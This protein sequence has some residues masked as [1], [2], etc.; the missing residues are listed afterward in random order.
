VITQK[1]LKSKL[2]YSPIVG[3]FEWRTAG[4]RI[5]QGGLAGGVCRDSGYVV[6]GVMGKNYL[7]HH[8]AW[9]YMTGDWPEMDIDHKDGDR[10]NNAFSNLRLATKRQNQ[11]NKAISPLNSSGEK[12]VSFDKSTQKWRGQVGLG[13]KRV[14]VGLFKTKE[15]ATAAVRERRQELHGEFA[16]HGQ[17]KYVIEEMQNELL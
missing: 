14:H 10:S 11:W 8:L 6:I 13:D 4:R 15:E 2:S 1:Q 3:V 16:N 7:A 17:H 5:T 9:L 12:G